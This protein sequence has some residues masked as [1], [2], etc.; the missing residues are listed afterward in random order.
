MAGRQ[1]PLM[2]GC[3]SGHNGVDLK[4]SVSLK[5]PVGSNPTPTVLSPIFVELQDAS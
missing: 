3:R 1:V 5:R 4:S 2:V